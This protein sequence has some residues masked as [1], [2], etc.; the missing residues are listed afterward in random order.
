MSKRVVVSALVI[1]LLALGAPAQAVVPQSAMLAKKK[2]PSCTKLLKAFPAGIARDAAASEWAVAADFTPPRVS[3]RVYRLNA[4]KLDSN[5]LGVLCPQPVAVVG[6]EPHFEGLAQ[7]LRAQG[8]TCLVVRSG[9]R[10]TGEWYWNGRTP[11]TQTI[12]FSTMKTVTGTLVASANDLGALSLDQAASD[13]IPSW[14]GTPSQDVTI[15]Q[16]LAMTSGRQNPANQVYDM[17]A[18]GNPTG[19]AVGLGQAAPPGTVWAYSDSAVQSLAAVLTAA[20]GTDVVSFAQERLL[21][22]LGMTSTT[23]KAVPGGGAQMAFD[24]TTSCRDLSRLTQV[25]VDSGAFA[26]RQLISSEYVQ[27]ARSPGSTL[28]P[29]FGLLLWNNTPGAEGSTPGTPG[30]IFELRGSCGQTSVGFP[31]SGTVITVMTSYSSLFESLGC[32]QDEQEFAN[33]IR[34]AGSA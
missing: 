9:G 32:P 12:G 27:Q 31:S 33:L 25:Y 29:N 16:L 19:Y 14:N 1:A 4:R 10:I 13:F 23:L 6:P 18:S 17:V 30:D 28:R 20:T 26:G 7:A 34:T 5:G 21:E 11:A 8:A 22:P 15:R 3:P 2:F 24:Y